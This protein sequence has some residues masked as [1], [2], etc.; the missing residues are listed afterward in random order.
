MREG[1]ITP[2]MH[3][4]Q[5]RQKVFHA[6]LVQGTGQEQ[7]DRLVAGVVC[8][9]SNRALADHG[10]GPAISDAN[11][12]SGGLQMSEDGGIVNDMDAASRVDSNSGPTPTN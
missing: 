10:C 12:C 5:H 7:G 9:Q 2:I 4:L 8:L 6:G 1:D 3:E 11:P